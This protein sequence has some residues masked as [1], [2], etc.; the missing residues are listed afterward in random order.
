MSNKKDDD[1]GLPTVR[2][3]YNG[4]AGR[5]WNI[6]CCPL[7]STI[8]LLYRSASVFCFPCVWVLFFRCTSR[9][10]QYLC[11]CWGW[12]YEDE[13]FLGAAALGDHSEDAGQTAKQMAADTDWVRAQDLDIFK[14]KRPQLFEGKIE[15]D[16]L[17]QG[18]V[19]D[20]WLVAALACAAENPDSIRRMFSTKEYNP[21]GLY[22]VKIFDPH[23]KKFIKIIVD[24]RIPCKKGTKVPRF[25]S[26][27]GNELWAIILEK[28][29]A[30]WYV[31]YLRMELFFR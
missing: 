19:G 21:R 25:M 24:D 17:C 28:A 22:K 5:L 11:F 26:P 30:K 18:A 10:H 13:S 31:V 15:P 8:G 9:L 29:Y 1:G 6:L 7:A 2:Q 23:A 12:P 14:G 16:D 4:D 20:C 27:N 3:V